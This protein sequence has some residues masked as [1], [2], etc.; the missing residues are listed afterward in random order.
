MGREFPV[1]LSARNVENLYILRDGARVI[2]HVGV[3]RQVMQTAGVDIPTACIG[4]VCTD[5]EYRKGGLAGSLVDL[6]I[7]RSIEAGDVLMPIS[8]KRTLYTSRGATSMGPQVVLRVPAAGMARGDGEY[9]VRAYEPGDWPK[10]ARLQAAEPV[11]YCWTDREPCTLESIRGYGGTCLLAE[12]ADGAA[13]AALLYCVGHPMYGG[14]TE[15]ARAVQF[16]GEPRAIPALLGH[17]AAGGVQRLEWHVLATAQPEVAAALL[18]A[19]ATGKSSITRWTILILQLARL[20]ELVGPAAARMGVELAAR[21]GR[22][23]VAAEGRSVTLARPEHQVEILFRDSCT[24]SRELASLP[25]ELR[26]ACAAAL[27]IRLP[28]YGINYV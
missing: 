9:T 16:L 3:L 5:P 17:A 6:A 23:T 20:V 8:G 21:D 25:V 7:R 13:A 2:S 28:D 1:L 26:T 10:L 14:S 11:R 12:R 27:P 19:G 15:C 18:A 22:L 24:W 4:A